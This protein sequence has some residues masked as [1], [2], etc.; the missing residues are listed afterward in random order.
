[1]T[2]RSDWLPADGEIWFERAVAQHRLGRFDAEQADWTRAIALDPDLYWLYGIAYRHRFLYE[3]I[4]SD[5]RTA[6][7]REPDNAK[8]YYN[9]AEAWRYRRRYCRALRDYRRA[10]AL[11]PGYDDALLGSGIT[12]LAL[13]AADAALEDL[14]RVLE[15]APSRV[16]AYFYRG[17]AYRAAGMPDAARADF[18]RAAQ[19]A[20]SNPVV[21]T[22]LRRSRP[23]RAAERLNPAAAQPA[24]GCQGSV[25]PQA[26]PVAGSRSTADGQANRF[27]WTVGM[28]LRTLKRAPSAAR[29]SGSRRASAVTCGSPET[30]IRGRWNAVSRSRPPSISIEASWSTAGMILRPPEAPSANQ[31]TPSRVAITGHMLAS[32]RL[33]GASEF[34]RPGR[35]SNHMMPLLSRMPVGGETILLPNTDSRVWVRLTMVPARSTTA[36]WVVQAGSR[37][38]CRSPMV[39]SR[40]S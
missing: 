3:E 37:A 6:R 36:R 2:R 14:S 10:I 33:P 4:R 1:M 11:R 28:S 26:S 13:G 21:Q 15:R 25:M 32:G 27:G 19:L 16:E 9:R 17:L 34:G 29:T 38:S 22:A 30:S 18:A 40:R 20:P 23:L 5:H 24:T 35:G 8:A 7:L 31:G 12:L 39:A